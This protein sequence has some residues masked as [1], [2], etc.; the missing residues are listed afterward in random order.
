[1]KHSTLRSLVLTLTAAAVPVALAGSQG[2][3][4]PE[5]MSVDHAGKK[6][7]ITVV[8][9]MD[10]SNNGW[11]Y[12]TVSKG[13][14]SIVVPVGYAVEI[15]FTNSDPTGVVHSLGIGQ[16]SEVTSPLFTN[17][18][19]VFAGAISANAADPVN[20]TAA[21]TTETISFVAD[22]AGDYAIICYVPGHTLTGMWMGFRVAEDGSVGVE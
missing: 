6:V 14:K 7:S 22:A 19:P 21:G 8:A 11:N 15:E 1:M 10:M 3:E 16:T 5:W 9:G 18:T 4:L 13:A 20:A 12:N 2:P 17:P